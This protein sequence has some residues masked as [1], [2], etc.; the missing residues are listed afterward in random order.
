MDIGRAEIEIAMLM[1]M[2]MVVM[3]VAILRMIVL[4][5]VMVAAILAQQEGAEKID[6][7]AQAGDRNRLAERDRRRPQQTRDAFARHA[8]RDDRQHD[9]AGEGGKIADLAGAE[10]E[11]VVAGVSAG[12]GI[13][14][15]RDGEGADMRRHVDPVRDHREGME[16]RA[17]GDL[18]QHGAGAQNDHRA[19]LRRVPRVVCAEE[20][21]LMPPQVDGAFV[22]GPRIGRPSDLVQTGLSFRP[23]AR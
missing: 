18:G 5:A 19:R 14:E 3:V 2:V 23:Q 9:G 12:I 13:G 1:L 4:V 22:H 21:M 10:R 6:G 17:T 11:A 7:E 15:G 8:Q 16:Q 20:D